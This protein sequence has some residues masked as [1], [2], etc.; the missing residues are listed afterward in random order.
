MYRAPHDYSWVSS[1][2]SIVCNMAAI[3]RPVH[4]AVSF[5]LSIAVE[6]RLIAKHDIV[7]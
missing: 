5:Y 3:L 1:V 4:V 2:M 6:T 7:R